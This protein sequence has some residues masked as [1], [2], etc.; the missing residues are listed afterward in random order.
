[1]QHYRRISDLIQMESA[2]Q[3]DNIISENRTALFD[4]QQML[5]DWQQSGTSVIKEQTIH[6]EH[7]TGNN[8]ILTQQT[9]LHINELN[10]PY[11]ILTHACNYHFF[12][13]NR[14]RVV[15]RIRRMP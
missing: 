1:M 7:E 15:G 11:L 4:T 10:D 5:I 3:D 9:L 6:K 8:K 14:T 2:I 13:V 12:T